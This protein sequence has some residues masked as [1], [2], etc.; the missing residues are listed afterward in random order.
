MCCTSPTGLCVTLSVRWT[1][2]PRERLYR[3]PRKNAIIPNVGPA[4]ARGGTYVRC[5]GLCGLSCAKRETGE[6]LFRPKSYRGAFSPIDLCTSR[7]SGTSTPWHRT[8]T[9]K[10]SGRTGGREDSAA[11]CGPT[12]PA[13]SSMSWLCHPAVTHLLPFP[14]SSGKAGDRATSWG[15]RAAFRL[16]IGRERARCM[17]RLNSPHDFSTHRH[18]FPNDRIKSLRREWM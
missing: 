9:S 1:L 11:T 16:N 13:R 12:G 10:L 2:T 14:T 17:G 4:G 6:P 7:N 3:L 15:G 8:S 18:G 5:G